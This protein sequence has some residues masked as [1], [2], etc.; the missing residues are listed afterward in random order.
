M[1]GIFDTGIFDHPSASAAIAGSLSASEAQD[2]T[3]FT[4]QAGRVGVMAAN[5]GGTLVPVLATLV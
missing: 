3:A 5:V 2:V 4:A 1:T